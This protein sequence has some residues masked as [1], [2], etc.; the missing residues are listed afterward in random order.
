MTRTVFS[1]TRVA[2]F[3]P[4][5][6]KEWAGISSHRVSVSCLRVCVCVCLSHAGIVLKQLNVGSRKQHHLIAQGL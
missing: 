4:P 5:R 2:E 3:L 6:R 1:P